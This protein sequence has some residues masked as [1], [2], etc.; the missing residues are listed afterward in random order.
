MI[1]K[2]FI[3]NIKEAC[4]SYESVLNINH[5]FGGTHTDHFEKNIMNIKEGTLFVCKGINFK[6]CYLE[7]AIN[8]KAICYMSEKDYNKDIPK[9]IVTDVRKALAIISL[10]FYKDDLF[11]I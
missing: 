7:D 11:K 8:N 1:A 3:D 5:R 10:N 6:Q 2:N 9:I 4:S